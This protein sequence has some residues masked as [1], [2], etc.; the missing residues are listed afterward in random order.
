MCAW[1]VC[2]VPLIA[3]VCGAELIV[4]G[5]DLYGT[6]IVRELEG[7]FGLVD[8]VRVKCGHLTGEMP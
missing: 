2:V 7:C 8:I 4:F 5:E 1:L 3:C 6:M